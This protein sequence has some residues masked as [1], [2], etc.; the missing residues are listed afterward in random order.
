MRL[1]LHSVPLK[2]ISHPDS[3]LFLQRVGLKGPNGPEILASCLKKVRCD[4]PSAVHADMQAEHSATQIIQ[5][6]ADDV[7]DE[8]EATMCHAYDYAYMVLA[9]SAVTL[10]SLSNINV[11]ANT[12]ETAPQV[13]T[14]ADRAAMR[15][16]GTV[17]RVMVESNRSANL[18]PWD[19]ALN[20]SLIARET[21]MN[22]ADWT[23][24]SV[25]KTLESRASGVA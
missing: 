25:L 3:Q 2:P 1:C 4:R 6:F 18:F 15:Q 13:R 8:N 22:V 23:G 17:M 20:L 16:C 12:G 5:G 10:L 9:H 19:M 7:R 11:G 24:E 14:D 21:G